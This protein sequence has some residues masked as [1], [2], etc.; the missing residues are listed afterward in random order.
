MRAITDITA[1]D[2]S[3]A[4]GRPG[5]VVEGLDDIEQCLM[6]IVKTIPGTDPLRPL[7]GCDAWRHIDAPV[8]QALPA[9]VRDVY[10][11]V[12]MWE[13]RAELLGVTLAQGNDEAHWR[14][15]LSWR[16]AAG[17]ADRVMEVAHG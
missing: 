17:G 6:I 13:P 16:P 8:D 1:A 7:F 14:I 3:P 5:E 2:W 11:A 9:V 12:E 15:R 10:A 4:L